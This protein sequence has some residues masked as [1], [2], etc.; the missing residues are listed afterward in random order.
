MNIEMNIDINID[1]NIE[2]DIVETCDMFIFIL[3]LL[4]LLLRQLLLWFSFSS[5]LCVCVCVCVC[6]CERACVYHS[7][8]YSSCSSGDCFTFRNDQRWTG[9]KKAL[10]RIQSSIL[11]VPTLSHLLL[12]L[13]EAILLCI[14][15]TPS[16]WFLHSSVGRSHSVFSLLSAFHL[17]AGFPLFSNL[18]R[19]T[20][21]IKQWPWNPNNYTA[22]PNNDALEPP[23]PPLFGGDPGES[24]NV[25][26][27]SLMEA[28]RPW[29][30]LRVWIFAILALVERIERI[31]RIPWGYEYFMIFSC[32]CRCRSSSHHNGLID[33]NTKA[34]IKNRPRIHHTQ[35]RD[36]IINNLDNLQR[37]CF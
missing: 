22:A 9:E 28:R 5:L 12:P 32:C 15:I 33:T 23:P 24:L 30:E 21:D 27:E 13:L 31:E 16:G 6:V 8:C 3:P 2:I 17:K 19:F 14:H 18:W 26:R 4:P 20:E 11:R 36:S 29:V 7:G 10:W 25:L 37:S 34:S 1:I 35:K